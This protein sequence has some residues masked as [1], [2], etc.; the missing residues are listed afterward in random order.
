[1]SRNF[2][3]WTVSGQEDLRIYKHKF[4]QRPMFPDL[5]MKHKVSGKV[6]VFDAKFKKMDMNNGDVDRSDLHQIHSYSGFYRNDLLAS[7]LIYPLSKDINIEKSHSTSIYGNNENE[8]SFIVDGIYVSENHSM[9]ELI[10]NEEA[11][12]SRITSVIN[13]N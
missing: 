1:M 13:T 2:P 9:K 5:V 10:K 8:I 11:F 12:V 4:Y 3:D 6:V 7:G